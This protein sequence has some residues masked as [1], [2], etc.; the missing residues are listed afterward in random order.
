MQ[1]H[2]SRRKTDE[3]AY[4][5]PELF[6]QD[7][8]CARRFVLKENL[9]HGG[10]IQHVRQKA[11]SGLAPKTS[12]L[13]PQA[14]DIVRQH[15]ESNCVRCDSLG[16]SCDHFTLLIVKRYAFWRYRTKAAC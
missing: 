12:A 6:C 9:G 7:F 10:Y 3:P 14:P 15:A 11:V 4:F 2:Q 13:R 16:Y 5:E 8:Y 1:T